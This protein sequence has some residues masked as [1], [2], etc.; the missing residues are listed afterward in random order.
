METRIATPH[1]MDAVWALT[2]DVYLQEGYCEPQESGRLIH[3]P[4]L[5]GIAE[6]I[7]Y[8]AEVDGELVGTNS[9][10]L[11]GPAGLHVDQDF[12]VETA[13]M[14]EW[15]NH[16]D[17]RLGASWRI[18]TDPAYHTTTSVASALFTA[19]ILGIL[20]YD[21]EVVLF[22]F[23]PKHARVYKRLLG[24]TVLAT[25]HCG[26]VSAPAV[27]MGG[28]TNQCRDK[29]RRFLAKEEARQA[30]AAGRKTATED[31]MDYRENASDV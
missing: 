2:H 7:V 13:V 4:H 3:Y 31:A 21:L 19:T 29:W 9:L 30:L 20:E 1:D 26:T 18:V 5:D 15:C 14:R 17:Y 23:N 25:G 27:L 28:Q 22:Q 8:I 11:D 6:T 24:L 16:M 12:P 10:T